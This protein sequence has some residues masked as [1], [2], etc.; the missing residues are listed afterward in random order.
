MTAREGDW[1]SPEVGVYGETYGTD[2]S[3]HNH[4]KMPILESGGMGRSRSDQV[5]ISDQSDWSEVC[6][7]ALGFNRKQ[8]IICMYSSVS[9]Q[10]RSTPIS[11]TRFKHDVNQI[12]Q[13]NCTVFLILAF[14]F[15]EYWRDCVG[16]TERSTFNLRVTGG[17]TKRNSV[18]CSFPVLTR[19]YC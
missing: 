8:L 3:P 19:F 15:I 17:N 16:N 2:K 5:P 11:T 6:S 12:V 10:I 14:K 18:A 13:Q 4:L 9:T 7:I 1:S